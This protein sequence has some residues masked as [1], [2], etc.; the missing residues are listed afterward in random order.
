[1][2]QPAEKPHFTRTGDDWYDLVICMLY[3]QCSKQV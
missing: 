2:Q 1:M 3:I